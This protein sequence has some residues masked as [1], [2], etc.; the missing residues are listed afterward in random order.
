MR[1][2]YQIIYEVLEAKKDPDLLVAFATT[3]SSCSGMFD[4]SNYSDIAMN[5]LYTAFTIQ[6]NRNRRLGLSNYHWHYSDI[7]KLECDPR[8]AEIKAWEMKFLK[9]RKDKI[10]ISLGC[11]PYFPMNN[12]TLRERLEKRMG[13]RPRNRFDVEGFWREFEECLINQGVDRGR[14]E[15]EDLFLRCEKIGFMGLLRERDL[16]SMLTHGISQ[17]YKYVELSESLQYVKRHHALLQNYP[18]GIR[19]VHHLVEKIYDSIDQAGVKKI[20]S[21]LLLY[22]PKD[23]REELKIM[24]SHQFFEAQRLAFGFYFLNGLNLCDWFSFLYYGIS[25][26]DLSRESERMKVKEI[27]NVEIERRIRPV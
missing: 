19:G 13:V 23:D 1:E 21:E 14:E 22:L 7:E 18:F 15:L 26:L 20:Y 5:A 8:Y 11:N 16:I 3:F 27:L 25:K 6:K 4:D 9:K 17:I 24:L 2:A 12:F 10:K